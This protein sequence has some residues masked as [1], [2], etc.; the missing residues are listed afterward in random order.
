MTYTVYEMCNPM[1]V[2]NDNK[3]KCNLFIN[4]SMHNQ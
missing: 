4:V 2:L 1:D 3:I